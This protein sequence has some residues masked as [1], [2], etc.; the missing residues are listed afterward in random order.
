[1]ILTRSA[2]KRVGCLTVFPGSAEDFPSDPLEDKLAA[3]RFFTRA[4]PQL[5]Q[6]VS[7]G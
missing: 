5:R 6:W 1:M 3:E 4:W 2:I 7:Q